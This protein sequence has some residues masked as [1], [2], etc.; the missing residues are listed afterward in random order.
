MRCDPAWPTP[1]WSVIEPL[2]P[3]DRAGEAEG[4]PDRSERHPTGKDVRWKKPIYRKRHRV[5]RLLRHPQAIQAYHS[6]LRR[7]PYATLF[8]FV[9]LASVRIWLGSIEFTS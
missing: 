1:K 3:V 2:S 7:A 4:Q 9:R 5:E 6:P 8:A